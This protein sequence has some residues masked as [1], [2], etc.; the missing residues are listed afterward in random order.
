METRTL[1]GKRRKASGSRAAARLRRTGKLPGIVYGHKI[2]PEAVTLDR[3]DTATL[4]DHGAHLVNLDIEGKVQACLFKDA[5]YDHLGSTLIHV[6]LTRVDLSE[7]V[8]VHVEVELRGT[9]K[10]ISDGGVLRSG[11][12]ELEVECLVSAIP[13]KIRVDIGDLELDQVLHV[14]DLKLEAGLTALSDPEA[15]IAM[16][17]QPIVKAEETE[18]AAAEAEAPSTEPEVIVKGKGEETGAPEAAGK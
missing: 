17:R 6:D 16:V 11:L 4:L 15:V 7:R 3:H 13:E 2:E 8:K 1:T 9:P 5:Q 18:E 10:G 12:K 14:K